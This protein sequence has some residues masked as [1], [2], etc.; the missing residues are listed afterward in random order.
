[1]KFVTN[2][3]LSQYSEP[4]K[5]FNS[6]NP[7]APPPGTAGNNHIRGRNPLSARSFRSTAPSSRLRGQWP[8]V[9]P[10]RYSR[11]A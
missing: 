10:S 2:D 9:R 5:C 1:V 3:V 11:G 7:M 4:G 6:K 8:S